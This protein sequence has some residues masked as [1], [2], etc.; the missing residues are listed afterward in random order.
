M[1]PGLV[2][3][4][5]F[6]LAIF[7]TT[8]AIDPKPGSAVVK[9]AEGVESGSCLLQVGAR[10]SGREDNTS[11][12]AVPSGNSV[13]DSASAG[14][15]A[16]PT[17]VPVTV[18]ANLENAAEHLSK[19]L[20]EVAGA[21]VLAQ[22]NARA[23]PRAAAPAS[24]GIAGAR[25]SARIGSPPT[26]DRAVADAG[27][28]EDSQRKARPGAGRDDEVGVMQM[29]SDVPIALDSGSATISTRAASAGNRQKSKRVLLLLEMI[30]P[31]GL[32]G[33]DRFYMG[34]VSSGIAK[35]V[36]CIAGLFVCGIPWAV[37]DQVGVISNGLRR[38]DSINFLGM[39]ADF[40]ELEIELAH[41]LSVIAIFA[42]V[43]FTCF[44]PTFAAKLFRL[45]SKAPPESAPE[46]DNPP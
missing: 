3:R 9:D 41:T 14:R 23:G 15:E 35:L 20:A 17:F 27:T 39:V 19:A 7:T 25:E 42:N 34:S 33:I 2:R 12:L 13:A 1:A 21:Q 4:R 18:E 11:P 10:P 26:R 38:K 30:P 31:C 43:I 6:A 44:L 45:P 22:L 29:R 28:Q 16:A 32:L 40:D 5:A 36:I 8:V 37:I 24:V 46:A